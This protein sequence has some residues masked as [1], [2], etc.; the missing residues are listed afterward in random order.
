MFFK[1]FFLGDVSSPQTLEINPTFDYSESVESRRFTQTTETGGVNQYKFDGGQFRFSL[2]FNLTDSSDVNLIR[3]Y[4]RNQTT[5]SFTTIAS[6]YT[7]YVNCRIVNN[8][9]PF[10]NYSQMQF[11]RFDGLIT[12]LSIGDQLTNRGVQKSDV[13][14]LSPFILDDP[15]KGILDNTIYVLG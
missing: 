2:P 4:W 15:I 11:D 12:L 1:Q 5:I 13:M 14:S 9:D 6:G 10:L 8:N 7:Q 3:D